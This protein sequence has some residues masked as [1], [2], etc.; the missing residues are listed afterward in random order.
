MHGIDRN[1]RRLSPPG[2][3]VSPTRNRG[4]SKDDSSIQKKRFSRIW[5]QESDVKNYKPL[6]TTELIP[7][8]INK[9]LDIVDLKK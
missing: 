2:T 5:L 4:I 7:P 3:G 6:E 1:L 9:H 8:T